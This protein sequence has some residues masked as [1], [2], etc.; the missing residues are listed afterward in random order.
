MQDP[1]IRLN[2]L[3]RDFLADFAQREL[4]HILDVPQKFTNAKPAAGSCIRWEM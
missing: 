1:T 2:K 4:S 3:A